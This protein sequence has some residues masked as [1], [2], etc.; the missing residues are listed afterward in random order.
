MLS[1][2][3]MSNLSHLHN[4]LLAQTTIR[5]NESSVLLQSALSAPL[6]QMDYATAKAIMTETKGLEGIEYLVILDREGHRLIQVG[7]S[8]AEAL[9][10]QEDAPFSENALHDA[11]FDTRIPLALDGM[12][13]GTLAMGLSTKFYIDA[14]KEAL[15]RSIAIALLELLFSALL[16]TSLNYWLGKKFNRL[17][18]Q[19]QAIAN[20]DYSQRLSVS[21]HHEYDQLVH[22]FNQM[23]D[24]IADKIT[25]LENAHNE[26]KQLNRKIIHL[27]NHDNLTQISSRYA[28][29][30]YLNQAINKKQS[31][32]L[33]LL[34]LDGFKLI[35]DAH[36]HSVGDQLLKQ[37][38][39]QLKKY[40]PQ[41][42]FIARLGGDEFVIILN[43]TEPKHLS[44]MASYLCLQLSSH[45]FQINT[46]D[47]QLS[48]SIGYSRFPNEAKDAGNLLNQADIAMYQ[49]KNAGK[50]T[51][52]A[53][54]PKNEP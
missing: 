18:Q 12:P 20:G 30:S 17:T 26:Q 24:A 25:Q 49:A 16:L 15:V 52:R 1:I 53:Y 13:L 40:A 51:Y 32:A 7:W 10:Q 41:D 29:D 47:I 28:L 8:D 43:D 48:I 11:R 54:D 36:G 3:I 44:A 2:L 38:A 23:T 27:V 9:P 45:L 35:N 31:L 42:A 22:S 34:D 50:Q 6:V 37:F 19:A 33:F 5:L 21:E 4:S 14:R 39:Q 46:V